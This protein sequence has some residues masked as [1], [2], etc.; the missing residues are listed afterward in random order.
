M[1]KLISLIL[2]LVSLAGIAS[3]N[4]YPAATKVIDV[5]HTLDFVSFQDANGHVFVQFGAEDWMI[6]DTA[7][8]MLNDMSTPNVEDDEV[9]MAIYNGAILR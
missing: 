6:G 7:A 5:D 8:L 2:V 4:I 3:A 9:V 1:K